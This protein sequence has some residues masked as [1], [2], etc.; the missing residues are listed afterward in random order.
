VGKKTPQ[1][2]RG[3]SQF[4]KTERSVGISESHL[5]SQKEMSYPIKSHY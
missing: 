2:N 5:Y 1:K 4:N 3:S